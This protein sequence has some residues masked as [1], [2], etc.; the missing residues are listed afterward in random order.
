[1]DVVVTVDA[2]PGADDSETAE[3]TTRLRAELVEHG[4]DPVPVPS[5]APPG[6]KGVASGEVG[7]LLVVLAT[8]G[9]VLTTLLGMLQAWLLRQSGSRLVLEVD[10]DRVELTGT[11]DEERRRALEFWLARHDVRGGAGEPES[12]RGPGG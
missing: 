9:G 2:G 12:E 6:S 5:E 11:T 10:G 4:L 7:S 3:L 1:M 8:S